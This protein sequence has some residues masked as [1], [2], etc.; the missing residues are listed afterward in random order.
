[1]RP[2]ILNFDPTA[3]E[4]ARAIRL[5][6]GEPRPV[7]DPTD[8]RWGLLTGQSEGSAGAPR[9]VMDPTDPTCGDPVA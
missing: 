6:P 2:V 7:A 1:M 8:P 3:G 4:E 5:H 9:Q